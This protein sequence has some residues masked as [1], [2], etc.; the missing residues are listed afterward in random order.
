MSLAR[1]LAHYETAQSPHETLVPVEVC[2]E[3][4]RNLCAEKI[5]RRL[6]RMLSPD[7][8]FPVAAKFPASTLTAEQEF[9]LGPGEVSGLRFRRP[10][11]AHHAQVRR[12]EI[13]AS[14][15]EYQWA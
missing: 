2:E 11:P 10:N 1:L 4:A 12:K 13:V 3:L 8:P 9:K 6:Y 7:S 15:Q 5:S 14:I